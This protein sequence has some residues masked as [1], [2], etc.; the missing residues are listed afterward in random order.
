MRPFNAIDQDDHGE[1]ALL[2]QLVLRLQQGLAQRR[3]LGLEG[4]LIDAVTNLG[5]LEHSQLP[6]MIC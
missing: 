5:R 2:L 4:F 3:H 1:T 6:D